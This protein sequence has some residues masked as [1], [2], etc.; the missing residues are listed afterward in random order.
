MQS[1]VMFK[2]AAGIL[3]A[4]SLQACDNGDTPKGPATKPPQSST[5]GSSPGYMPLPS[6]MP[7]PVDATPA[8]P[9]VSSNIETATVHRL[10]NGSD[11]LPSTSPTEGTGAGYHLETGFLF[12]A[13][14]GDNLHPLYRCFGPGH[15]FSVD[16]GCEGYTPEGILGYLHSSPVPGRVPIYRLRN[17]FTGV[18][19]MSYDANEGASVGYYSEGVVGYGPAI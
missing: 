4:L 14:A 18:H 12:Y 8:L 13:T 17:Q 6:P 16:P 10:W 15:F 9:S 3:L 19:M 11:Y 2:V 7:N 1:K 5:S